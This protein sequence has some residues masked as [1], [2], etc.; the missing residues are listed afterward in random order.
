MP[1]SPRSGYRSLG[2]TGKQRSGDSSGGGSPRASPAG[3]AKQPDAPVAPTAAAKM[4]KLRAHVHNVEFRENVALLTAAR[5]PLRMQGFVLGV[6]IAASTLG[7]LLHPAEGEWIYWGAWRPRPPPAIA[8]GQV[9][10]G[11]IQSIC[12]GWPSVAGV[13]TNRAAIQPDGFGYVWL[14]LPPFCGW[15]FG[16]A[17][18]TKLLLLAWYH[19]PAVLVE[20]FPAPE[21][22]ADQRCNVW[23]EVGNGM[24][25][26]A[27]VG[28]IGLW[29]HLFSLSI[30][31]LSVPINLW[32]LH[33][34]GSVS[35]TSVQV[36]PAVL[37]AALL[38]QVRSDNMWT[39]GIGLACLLGGFVFL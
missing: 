30:A 3:G 32:L 34:P 35:A 13:E 9:R 29:S 1:T 4:R 38:A 31:I 2:K 27:R 21:L 14:L 15:W 28:T 25:A 37:P 16:G 23:H 6:W 33:N 7:F 8:W 12:V 11:V 18:L 17:T 24:V 26:G 36:L 5:G 39:I 22:F 10:L 20:C 19:G